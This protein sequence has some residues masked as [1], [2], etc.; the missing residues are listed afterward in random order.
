ME[1]LS[2]GPVQIFLTSLTKFLI[3]SKTYLNMINGLEAPD[4]GS[5]PKS[6]SNEIGHFFQKKTI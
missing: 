1:N 2:D 3:E 4:R 5:T 6:S